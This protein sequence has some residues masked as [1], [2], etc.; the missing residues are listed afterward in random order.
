M[1]ALMFALSVFLFLSLSFLKFKDKGH[2]KKVVHELKVFQKVGDYNWNRNSSPQREGVGQEPPPHPWGPLE[3]PG[4]GI[5]YDSD[6]L[7][8]TGSFLCT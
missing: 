4:G 6:E 2:S 1:A 8:L 3:A 5:G 7:P